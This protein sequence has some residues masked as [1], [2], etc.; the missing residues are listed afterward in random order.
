MELELKI[1]KE[2][3]KDDEKE[4]GIGGIFDDEKTSAEHIQLLKTKY[5]AMRRDADQQGQENDRR[6]MEIMGEKFM[7]T[8]QLEKNR[9]NMQITKTRVNEQKETHMTAKFNLEKKVREE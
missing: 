5:Q 4:A 1:L 7:L 9:Q 2:K 6:K 8:A 3:C